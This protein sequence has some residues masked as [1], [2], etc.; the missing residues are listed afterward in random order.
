MRYTWILLSFS[1]LFSRELYKEI[2]IE[3][4]PFS[5]IPY[6][7]SLGIDMDHIYKEQG[8]IQFAISSYDLDKLDS[9][10]VNY[11]IIH[12]NLEAFYAQR[13][14]NNFE[15]RDFELGS[16][17]GYYTFDEI[18][19]QLNQIHTEYPSLTH[20]EI[21]GN[22]LEGRNVW[23]LKISDNPSFFEEDEPEVLYTGLHHAREPMSYM[24]LFYF[25]DWLFEN[26]NTD[27]LATHL[28][29]NR[30]LWFVPAV[31]PDGLVYNQSIAP[32]GGG[33]Q[34]KNMLETCSGGVDGV[35]LN[36]NYSYMWGYDN[37]GSSS[38]GC[39]ETYRGTSPFSEPE[40][41]NIRDFVQSHNFPIAF[42]YHSY[43]NLLI[44]PLGYEYD[45]PVPEE[46]LEIFIEYGEDMVQYNGYALGSGPDLLYPV[47]GEACD[48]MYGAENI[49]A[50]TPEIGSG[51]DGFWPST[52]RII[53]LAEENLYPNQFLA[54]VAGSK[55]KIE[56]SVD[57]G[58][59]TVDN[60]YPLYISVF[61]QGLSNSN[62][63]VYI[64]IESSNNLS[65]ELEQIV[66]DS[67]LDA[68]EFLDLGGI[69]YFSP[70][71][72]QGSIGEITVNIYDA[73]NYIYSQSL[74]LIIGE[75]E[76]IANQDFEQD[77]LWSIGALDDGATAGIWESGVPLA[78]YDE[79]GNIVQTDSDHTTDGINCFFTGN[80]NNPN[81]PGQGD[82]DGG[83][84]TLLSPVYD[85]SD[86]SGVIVSYWKWY[87]NNQGNNPG[88]DIWKVD[89]S[90][91]NGQSWTELENT[92][93][94][95]NF[96]DFRQ[97]YLNNYI[98]NFNAIQFRFIAEDIYHDGDF[99]SGGSLVE[100]A[101]DDFRIEGFIDSSCLLG[102]FNA[103]A[104][105]NVLDIISMVNVI[106][107]PIENIND[108]LCVGD[109]NQDGTLNIQDVI[110]LV[111]FIL[112]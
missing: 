108:Y 12:D 98:D 65:F 84:T 77:N 37:E 96:W 16:M 4:I 51:S 49:F 105:I 19:E 90:D 63:E 45:N 55:Y 36:R 35:D 87:T 22:T 24:N 110:M 9:H 53:P 1:L 5:T 23:A 95:N 13:L 7:S 99:G 50:Y 106:L 97:F 73:D 38:D 39:N 29:N 76:I 2:R 8:F 109:F 68:R 100:A 10:N 54:L 82:V 92:N 31:N 69:S 107:G 101:I 3:N 26:Y 25:M 75:T 56:I 57:E 74:Q 47:N 15:S 111:N 32:N 80:S 41:Q 64:D 103:D 78:T 81:S 34:R 72:I 93:S 104:I 89:V 79:F 91:N 85:L 94:S 11:Q 20:L 42:N 83:K 58:P 88:T 46:D 6:L 30:Q 60:V 67:G 27:D 44:Y 70:N 40:S 17:G 66:L 48:W 18:E 59:Y 14:T 112:S 43:S 61:N 62:Q 86:Y 52:N 71:T 21:I 33:M 102:D 28:I